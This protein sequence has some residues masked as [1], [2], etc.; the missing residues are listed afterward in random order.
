MVDE[1]FSM[2]HL[3]LVSS[4]LLIAPSLA[5]GETLLELSACNDFR[6]VPKIQAADNNLRLAKTA[7]M[8]LENSVRDFSSSCSSYLAN[9]DQVGRQVRAVNDTST[10]VAQATSKAAI[11]V[12]TAESELTP[13]PE[14]AANLK[15]PDCAAQVIRE[16]QSLRTRLESIRNSN[17]CANSKPAPAP[18][19]DVI[20]LDE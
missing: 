15:E 7:L 1:L 14:I 20:N 4:L 11:A 17:F 8:E 5:K 12:A 16:K 2:A 19:P 6:Q 9:A 10:H 13:L 18:L 3:L